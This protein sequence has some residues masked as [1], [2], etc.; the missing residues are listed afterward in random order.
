MPV[1]PGGADPADDSMAGETRYYCSVPATP[2]PILPPNV[3]G[4]RARAIITT[5]NKW[6]NGTL[7]H[8]YFFD[9]K[10][11]DGETVHF[12]NGT[13]EWRTW[14]GAKEQLAVVRQAFEAWKKIGI[15]LEFKEVSSREEAEVRV[16]FMKGDGSWSYIGTSVLDFGA[17]KRTMNFGWD[18]TR[19]PDGLDTALHE[20]GHTLGL[21][22]EHQNPYAGIV[23]DEEAVY[24]ELARPPNSWE[25]GKTFYNII[26]K[27]TPDTV[28]GSN[29]DANSI[30]HYPFEAGLIRK[31]EDY[32]G[33]LHPQG[34]LSARDVAWVKSFYPSLEGEAMVELKPSQSQQLAL[35][36]GEQQN[37]LF[38]P[39]ATRQYNVQT[40]GSSDT[41]IALFE[42]VDGDWRYL[43]ADDDGGE[44]RNASLRVKLTS[45][46]SYA[47]RVRLKYS[48]TVSSPAVM[49][50]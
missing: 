12:S 27:I 50:W 23:W 42:N 36:D 48:G 39:S 16:G 21:P 20:I 47:L 8:Y 29:W 10:E 46:R 1:D 14:V 13:K 33:G 25:R 17:N 38:K 43:T 34:G 45:G 24:A 41:V 32:A 2:E 30:M 6:V 37:F 3:T 22:H 7:I 28:Q 35:R 26:R 5:A 11:K 4:D 31:P 49:L 9:N 18:L 40:F 44:E 15:G 19:G